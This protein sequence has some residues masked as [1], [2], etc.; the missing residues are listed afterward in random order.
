MKKYLQLLWLSFA[1]AIMLAGAQL[2]G[3]LP[4]DTRPYVEKK[5]A[6]WSGVLRACV[7]SE[8]QAGASLTRWLKARAAEFEK[9][10]E[11]VYIEFTPVDKAGLDKLRTGGLRPPELIFF[12]PGMLDSADGLISL[13]APDDL[14]SELRSRHALPVAMGGYIWVYNRALCPL[15]PDAALAILLPDG[16]GRNFSRALEALCSGAPAREIPA[17]GAGL[18]I[19]LPTASMIPARSPDALERFIAG[20]LGCTIVTQAELAR[21]E[22]LRD[23]GRGPD[24]ACAGGGAYAWTDQLLYAAATHQGGQDGGAREALA[25]EFI[26]CLLTEEAQRELC[27]A[28]AFSVTGRRVHGDLSPWGMLDAQLCSLPLRAVPP[29]PEQAAGSG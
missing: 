15:G 16:G 11:G 2:A 19:G 21:L 10:H 13:P 28:G 14:R 17:Q 9:N 1:C 22:R 27:G 29:F 5:Y 6:G 8:W 24:W 12:S 18:D 26:A 20:D 3:L 23:A 4:V 7:C 25:R